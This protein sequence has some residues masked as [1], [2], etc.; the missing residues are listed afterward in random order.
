MHTISVEFQSTVEVNIHNQCSD[1]KLTD[2]D[3]FSDGADWNMW[4]DMEVMAGNMIKADLMPFLAVFEGILIYELLRK[5]VDPSDQT[6][7]T[8]N[9]LLVAWKSE[10]YKKFHVLVQLIECNVWP[11]W[12]NFKPEEY[13]QRYAS[14]LCT[15]TD[16]IEDTWLIHDGTVLTTRLELDFTQRDGVLNIVISEGIRDDHTKRPEWINLKR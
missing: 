1:F 16:P 13:Y 2:G 12:Y 8:L 7:S 10:G 5:H 4:P 9:L 6:K 14:Q 3:C 15:Y 11:Y